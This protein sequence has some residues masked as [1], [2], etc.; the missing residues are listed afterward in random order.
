MRYLEIP[1]N[2]I[3]PKRGDAMPV[4]AKP[5][6]DIEIKKAKPKEKDY[7]LSDGGGLYLLITT[8]GGKLWRFNY[9]FDGKHKT[10]SLKTYPER[11]LADARKDRDDARKLIA[12]GVDPGALKKE[13]QA[14]EQEQAATFKSIALEW[15][16]AFKNKWTENHAGR[17][18]T[19]LEQDFFPFLGD[20]PIKEIKAPALLD[21]LRRVEIRS[22][23]QAHKL[24]GTCNQIF[25]YAIASGRADFNPAAGLV[26]TIAPV[27]HKHMAAPVDPKAVTPLLRAIDG[28]SGSFVVKCALQLAPMLFVRPGELRKAEWSEFNLDDSV[29]NIPAEKMKM[30]QPHLVPLPHQAVK[31]IRELKELTGNG[32]YLFPCRRST[33]APMSDNTINASLRRLGFDKDEITGHGFRAMARTMLHEILQ[34]TPDAIEAQLAHAVPD[35]LGRAYNRTTHLAERTKMMQTW[36]DYLDGLKAGCKVLPFKRSLIL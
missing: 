32:K 36:A 34:F 26:G 13:Q 14:I 20:T 16:T 25:S 18:L 12:N 28:F 11:S 5:L 27:K 6:S 22:V 29:W 7:K 15:H 33:V 21:L 35:R 30:R 9:R 17:L 19:R 24:R 3:P 2:K 8:S 31:I 1:P 10:L 4:K 23:E